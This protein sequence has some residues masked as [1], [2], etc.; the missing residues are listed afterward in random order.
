MTFV[1][2]D[3]DD[4]EVVIVKM[5]KKKM[6]MVKMGRTKMKRWHVENTATDQDGADE[7][8]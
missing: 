7:M 5:V 1:D 6:K 4:D 2:D 3:D 8:K